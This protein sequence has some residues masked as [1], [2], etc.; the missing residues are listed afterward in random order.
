MK[1]SKATKPPKI[2]AMM[3]GITS[4]DEIFPL[5]AITILTAGFICPPEIREVKRITNDK[6]EPWDYGSLEGGALVLSK[7]GL[8]N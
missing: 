4:E 8:N 7:I 5:E 2:C 3:Y 1:I 6:Q